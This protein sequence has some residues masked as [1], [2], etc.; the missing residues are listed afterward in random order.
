MIDI[1]ALN[2]LGAG[3]S[4]NMVDLKLRGGGVLS[5]AIGDMPDD[6]RNRKGLLNLVHSKRLFSVVD[7]EGIFHKLYSGNI[8]ELKAY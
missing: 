3:P 7:S 5:V 6:C 1:Q 8:T 4:L 2:F